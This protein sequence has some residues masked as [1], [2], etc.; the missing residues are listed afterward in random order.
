MGKSHFL[1]LLTYFLK[2]ASQLE[3]GLDQIGAVISFRTLSY[4]TYEGVEL[5]ETLEL[6]NRERRVDMNPHLRR[7][8]GGNSFA[9]VYSN[10]VCL[11]WVKEHNFAD[12]Q[13]IKKLQL[14]SLYTKETRQ[15]LLLL[16]RRFNPQIQSLQYLSD[17]IVCNHMLLRDLEIVSECEECKSANGQLM[18]HINLSKKNKK[19]QPARAGDGSFNTCFPETGTGNMF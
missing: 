3:I 7:A 8:F 12:K 9:R 13:H 19:N 6:A 15:L 17:L 16:L 18:V 5:L 4:I 10:G 14:Q 11:Q 1:W 2:F